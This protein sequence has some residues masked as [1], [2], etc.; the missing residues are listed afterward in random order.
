VYANAGHVSGYLL[1]GSGEVGHVL[2]SLSLPLGFFPNAQYPASEVLPLGS[3]EIVALLTDGITEM[4]APE[5]AGFFEARRAIKYIGEHRQ[6]SASRIS[7]GLYQAARTFAHNQP[8]KDD[9][10][11]VIFKVN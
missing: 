10:S 9:V 11:L 2:E 4:A 6:E 1:R 3:G 7:E 8:Q 5:E